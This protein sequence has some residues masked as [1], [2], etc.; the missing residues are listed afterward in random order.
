[1]GKADIKDSGK[2]VLDRLSTLLAELGNDILIQGHADDLPINTVL[3][4]S[5]WELSTKRA[6]NVVK[7]LVDFCNLPPEKLTATG[8][9]EFRPIK[10]NDTP[11]NRQENRRVDIVIADDYSPVPE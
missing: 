8:N 6:T 2:E 3:F 7:Y 11:E 9:G 5:N 10:P 4:P 1:L